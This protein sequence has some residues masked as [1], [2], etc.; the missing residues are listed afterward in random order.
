ML[1]K[2]AKLFFGVSVIILIVAI[3]LASWGFPK[4]VQKQIHKSLQIQNSS[5]MFEKWRELP[6]PLKF[7]V[8]LFNVTNAEDVNNGAKPI[9]NEIGPYVYKEYRVKRILGYGENDTIRYMLKKTFYFDQEASGGLNE[10]DEVTVINYSYLAALLTV[11]DIMPA[12]A[13]I[14]NNALES[15]F[16]NLTDPFM[17]VKVKDLLFDG[18]FLNCVGENSALSLVCGKIRLEKPSVMRPAED[19]KGF[20]FSMFSH[21]NLTESGPYDMKRGIENINEL[22]HIVAYNN[23]TTMSQWGDPYCGQINGSDSSIFPPIEG[24]PPAKISTFEPEICR[25]FF[26]SL[27]GPRD[28]FNLSAYYYEIDEMLFASKSANPNNKCFCKRNW[29]ANHDGCLLMGLLNINPCKNAPA[30][31]SLPHF[32]LASEE[33]LEYFDGGISPDREK[34]RSF[35]YLEATTGVVIKGVQRL[36]FNIELRNVPAIPELENVRTGLFPLLWIE[37]GAEISKNLQDELHHA[38]KLLSYVE[39]VRWVIL[40][41]SI[42]LCIASAI[43]VSRTGGL[44]PWPNRNSVNFILRPGNTIDINKIR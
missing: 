9:L 35:V 6:I 19:D 29:S 39:A 16:P 31:V 20:Y 37:E 44:N 34:H 2:N 3:V 14:V 4:I 25:S 7:K 1:G 12:A 23:K 17:K 22:G 5:V 13:V 10:N 38:N 15:F 27:V 41:L 8:Y 21:L 36:Q 40:G 43:Y 28:I 18:I 24:N 42:I 30:I 26:A 33:I 11:L 32:Y